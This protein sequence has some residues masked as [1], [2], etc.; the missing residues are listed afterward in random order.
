M[1]LRLNVGVS[2][3]VGLPEYSSAGAHCELELEVESGLLDDL[4]RS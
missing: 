1:P 4:D 3:K 2:K